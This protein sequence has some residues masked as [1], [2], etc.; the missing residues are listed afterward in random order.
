MKNLSEQ[1]L[2]EQNLDETVD[3]YRSLKLPERL[4]AEA[5]QVII[6]LLLTQEG[7]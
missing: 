6:N 5:A 7:Q 3:N 4:T 1:L 2:K